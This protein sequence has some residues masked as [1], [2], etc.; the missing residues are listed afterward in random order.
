MANGKDHQNPHT[1]SYYFVLKTLSP[2]IEPDVNKM[3]KLKRKTKKQ[4]LYLPTSYYLS[5]R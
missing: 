5:E 1:S 3:K 2:I 4:R